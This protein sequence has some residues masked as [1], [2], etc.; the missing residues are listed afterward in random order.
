MPDLSGQTLGKYQL[1]ERLGRGGMADVYK[2]YQPGLDRY[3]AVKVLHP[4]LSE[5]PGF[6]TRFKREARSVAELRHPHIVQVF[7]FDVQ[8]ENYYMVMEYVEGG[9]TLKQLLQELSAKGERLPLDTTLGIVQEMADALA[10]AH[11]L[12]MIHRDIKPANILIPHVNRPVLS[13]FGIARLLGETG[14]TSS[15]QM[16]GTP[17]YMSPEQGKGERGD[18]RSDIYAL[19]I[20]L[21][22][23]LTGR[24]PY[25]ADTP[26]AVILK[27]INDPLVPPHAL[28]GPLPDAIERIVLKCLAKNP[29]DRFASMAELR[30]ALRTASSELTDRKTLDVAAPPTLTKASQAAPPMPAQASTQARRPAWLPIAGLAVLIGVAALLVIVMRGQ[31]PAQPPRSTQPATPIAG[32]T[33]APEQPPQPSEAQALIDEGYGLLFAGDDSA[34]TQLFEKA[35]AVEP[36]NPN[37]WVA[38]AVAELARYGDGQAAAADLERAAQVIPGDPFLHYGLGLLRNRADG[39]YDAETAER[40]LTQAIDLCGDR[41]ALCLSAY[42]ER[43]G[44]RFWNLSGQ[45]AGLADINRAIELT[46]DPYALAYLHSIRAGFHDSAGDPASAVDDYQAAYELSQSGEYLE[47][48]AAAAVWAEQFDRA[49]DFY[50]RLLSEQ[51]GNPHYLV[52]RGY[53][54][55]RSGDWD[56]A[57]QTAQ[58]ALEL[59][60]P[61]EGHYLLGLLLLDAGQPQ[62]ALDEFQSVAAVADPDLLY[63][64]TFPFLTQDFGHEIF[65]DMARAAHALGD[66]DAALG[67]IEQSLQRDEDWPFPYVERGKILAEQ[68]DLAGAR[69]NYLR[70]LDLAYD[71][72]DLQ[73]EINDLLVGL[74]K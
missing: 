57:M 50:E 22:E 29:E 5:D 13:D 36:D 58:R 42:V 68:K 38:R 33:R 7:D 69:E 40:E 66:P 45:E 55:W 31:G 9:Q 12:G 2:G 70:A 67:F 23:M 61:L 54:E 16:V 11:G 44:V 47:K 34:A 28:I 10:Y 46:T 19:G 43:A 14:L 21:Y 24:P 37:V 18:V 74:T 6:I 62:E 51:A 4:H 63:Q 72:P 52:N 49:L 1:I 71:D 35:A 48:A 64:A 60:E 41:T 8:G 39:F 3:V 26:Y 20:V 56:R 30:E 59:N 32:A 25:D 53:V 17:A 65:F 73:A 15:G 27:H